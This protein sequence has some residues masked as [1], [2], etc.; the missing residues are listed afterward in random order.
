MSSP[1]GL[2][3][4]RPVAPQAGTS[5]RRLRV[6]CTVEV[7]HTAD[8]CYAHVV[9]DGV[10]V[11]PGDEVLVHGAPTRIAWGERLR[12]ERE[13]TVRRAG[14]LS[15]LLTRLTARFEL[16]LLY[17]V[18]FSSRRFSPKRPYPRPPRTLP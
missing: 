9:L 18:S 17:E 7:A 10:E 1:L 3:E 8:E 5:P 2:A 13:A 4:A 12:V 6:P 15:R 14:W 11:G 16:S